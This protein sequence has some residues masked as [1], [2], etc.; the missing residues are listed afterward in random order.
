MALSSGEL[1]GSDLEEEAGSSSCMT[2][3]DPDAGSCT[4]TNQAE[5]TSSGPSGVNSLLSK[6]RAPLPS[7]LARKRKV[8]SNP[9]TGVKRGKGAV[10]ADPKGVTP[11][12]RVRAY[13][14]E[15]FSVSNKKLFCSA[16]REDVA[17][18]KSVI[19]LHVKSVKHVRGK[20]RLSSKKKHDEDII[21]ALDKYDHEF[22]PEG[23][24]LPTSV[25]FYRIKVVC[26]MLKGGVPLSKVDAFRDLLEEEAF[27][28]TSAT[29]LRQLLPFIRHQEIDILK[30]EISLSIIF[31]GTTHVCEAMVLVVRYISDSWEIQQRVC[32]MML[33]AKSMTGEEVSRQIITA[34]STELGTA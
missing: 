6:L 11:A 30:K 5:S 3:D 14:N 15:P 8:Q 18:K 23:E 13:P 25:R 32:R 29:N 17:M 24:T 31:D 7:D 9:P 26:S 20:K 22:H 12:D 19:D 34:L 21:Q 10:A 27:A 16:C 28:L 1:A 33:L 4:D 2:T